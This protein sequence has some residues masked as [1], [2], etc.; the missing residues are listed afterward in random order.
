MKIEKL[1]SGSYRIRKKYK[2]KTY[3]VVL[4][5]KPTQKEAMELMAEKLNVNE[6]VSDRSMTLSKAYFDYLE[7]KSNILSPSTIRGYKSAYNAI[8]DTLLNERISNIDSIMVQKYIND[9]S[10]GHSPKTVKNVYGLISIL[11]KTY[12]PGCNIVVQLP[13]M[14]KKE[15]YIPTDEEMKMIIDEIRETKYYVPTALAALGL[16]KSEICALDVSDLKE[17]NMLVINKA[18]VADEN[19]DY[20]LKTTKTTDSTRY[21]YIPDDIAE[22]IREQG[23]IYKGFPDCITRNL[24]R[25]QNRLGIQNFPLHKLRHFFASY[26]HNELHLS[27]AQIMEAGGWKSPDIMRTVYR[28]SMKEEE[29]KKALAESMKSL[30]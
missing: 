17:N 11:M 15:P 18:L 5:Y 22:K 28:H 14:I 12:R 3:S 9:Y 10:V 30:F 16:R 20:V 21:I 24:K 25:V 26:A 27:D 8:S 6:T 7:L 1:P 23:Y 19:G 2:N 13:Q 4:D 29:A